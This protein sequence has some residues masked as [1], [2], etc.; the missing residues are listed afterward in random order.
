MANTKLYSSVPIFCWVFFRTNVFEQALDILLSDDILGSNPSSKHRIVFQLMPLMFLG[1]KNVSQAKL[2]ID[3]LFK[4][5]LTSEWLVNS[6]GRRDFRESKWKIYI[7]KR[8]TACYLLGLPR[9]YSV[10][11]L[12]HFILRGKLALK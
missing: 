1:K 4:S 5:Q 2:T 11:K 7:D 8:F 6:L 3:N 10:Q 9:I 12:L